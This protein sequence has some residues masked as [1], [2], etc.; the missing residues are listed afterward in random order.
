MEQ[1]SKLHGQALITPK[2]SE[3]GGTMEPVNSVVVILSQ[4]FS[5][6]SVV[7]ENMALGELCLLYVYYNSKTHLHPKGCLPPPLTKH[8]L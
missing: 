4:Q 2:G 6:F 3:L 8:T 1:S 5:F 7:F